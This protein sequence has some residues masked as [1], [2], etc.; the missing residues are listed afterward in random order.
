MSREQHAANDNTWELEVDGRYTRHP[1][2]T[3]LFD[4]WES[5]QG[6]WASIDGKMLPAEDY[7]AALN[8]ELARYNRRG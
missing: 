2:L 7:D 4:F 1:F 8:P 3:E 6:A 5:V